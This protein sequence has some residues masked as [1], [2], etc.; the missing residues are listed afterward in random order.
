VG[1]NGRATDTKAIKELA[2]T[3]GKLGD[4][5]D[6]YGHLVYDKEYISQMDDAELESLKNGSQDNAVAAAAS[7]RSRSNSQGRVGSHRST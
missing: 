3:G 1:L 2:E 7:I 6:T 4:A 5:Y